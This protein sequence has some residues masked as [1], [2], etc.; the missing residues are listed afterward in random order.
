M[1]EAILTLSHALDRAQAREPITPTLAK[2]HSDALFIAAGACNPSGIAHSILDACREIRAEPGTGTAEITG[3]PAVRLMV[4]QL[5][6]ICG[7]ISGAEE[8]TREPGYSQCTK[9]CEAKAT[10][11]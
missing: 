5:A 8:L 1:A 2:R 11:L 6:F 4:H 9:A 7:V 3:D 10:G